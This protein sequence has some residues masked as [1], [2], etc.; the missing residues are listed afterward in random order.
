MCQIISVCLRYF[1]SE[2]SLLI[3]GA[4]KWEY[5]LESA[6]PKGIIFREQVLP[7]DG[8]IQGE[9]RLNKKKIL[10]ILRP[11]VFTTCLAL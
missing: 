11:Y 9:R 3:C 2:V 4:L 6:P 10:E 8:L 7:L 1:A 5:V